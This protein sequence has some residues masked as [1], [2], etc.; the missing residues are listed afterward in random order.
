LLVPLAS[1]Q[2]D[3]MTPLAIEDL[4]AKAQLIL[5]GNVLSTTV[6][7]DPAGRIYTKIDLQVTEV[8]KGTLATNHFTIVHSGGVLGE[9]IATASGEVEYAV[10]EEVVA[11]LVINPQGEGVSIGLSQGK[12]QVSP[13]PATGEKLV[14]NRFHGLHPNAANSSNPNNSSTRIINRLTLADLKRRAQGGAQ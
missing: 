10:G 8:W 11:F 5:H 12:F 2:A 1:L 6:Q 9:E 7:R 13:D 14:H 3:Q 4:T